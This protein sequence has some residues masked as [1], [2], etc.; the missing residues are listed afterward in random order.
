MSAHQMLMLREQFGYADYTLVATTSATNLNYPICQGA[1]RG[2]GPGQTGDSVTPTTFRGITISAFLSSDDYFA[3]D[4]LLECTF[5]QSTTTITLAS[6]P[7]QGINFFEKIEFW[8]STFSTR[9]ATLTS[10]SSTYSA[11]SW[12]W[13]GNTISANGN[14]YFRIIYKPS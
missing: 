13:N 3:D 10:A 12:S 9:T 6:T 2:Y 7:T 14:Y 11:G 8:N 1:T 4:L 5:I